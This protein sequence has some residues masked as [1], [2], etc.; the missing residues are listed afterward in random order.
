MQWIDVFLMHCALYDCWFASGSKELQTS[1]KAKPYLAVLRVLRHARP[2]VA[3]LEN[4]PG[5]VR[6]R[7][8][9]ERT[10]RGV[11][12]YCVTMV[13]L[14][15]RMFGEPVRRPRIYMVCVRAAFL[16][17]SSRGAVD[18]MVSQ[19]LA[20]MV[21]PV[22]DAA[23]QRLL[24]TSHTLVKQRLSSRKRPAD[25]GLAD[26]PKAKRIKWKVAHA[27]FRRSHSIANAGGVPPVQLLRP[28]RAEDAWSLLCAAHPSV[29]TADV[30]QSI[31]RIH[32]IYDGTLPT[33]TP[34]GIVIVRSL[35]RTMIG[36]E[37]LLAHGFPLH[38]MV[39]P[40]TVT[41]THLHRLGGQTMSVHC[42]AAAIL[43]GCALVDWGA[44]GIKEGI[45]A[46]HERRVPWPVSWLG[47]WPVSPGAPKQNDNEHAGVTT[48]RRQRHRALATPR[49]TSSTELAAPKRVSNTVRS[50][51]ASASS[52]L[53]PLCP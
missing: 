37:K 36:V 18:T 13:R 46:S 27:A 50:A 41:E 34:N 43:I 51:G 30:S 20:S 12:G 10:L 47:R 25:S 5:I 28:G 8:H 14:D 6:V 9:L 1:R 44:D 7:A 2:V 11:G 42:V 23:S 45:A 19:V 40:E 39:I 26:G 52:G 16:L 38:R 31:D 48:V 33:L 22:V 53:G 15:P 24:P 35:N 21:K 32:A 17:C 29:T 49:Q 4:V 3:V